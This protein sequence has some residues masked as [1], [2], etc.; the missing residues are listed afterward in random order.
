MLFTKKWKNIVA[1]LQC[2]HENYPS[3]SGVLRRMEHS[4]QEVRSLTYK[5]IDLEEKVELLMAHLGVTTTTVP[6]TK[7]RLALTQVLKEPVE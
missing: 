2:V 5:V 1:R 3:P 6:A 4:E 7:A